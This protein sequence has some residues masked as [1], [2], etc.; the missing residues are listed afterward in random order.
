[1]TAPREWRLDFGPCRPITLNEQRREHWRTH[2]T[3][4]KRFRTISA[5]LARQ[6][7][8]PRVGRVSIEVHYV[9]VQARRRDPMNLVATLKPIEDGIVDAGVIP[10]DTP[11]YSVPTA[12]VI[13]EPSRR[14]QAEVYVL[15]R[16]VLPS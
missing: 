5:W 10:D 16:E 2:A 9:P 14:A 11:A 15:V 1:M 12:P 6:A 8:I 13:D 7:K 3:R 4:V